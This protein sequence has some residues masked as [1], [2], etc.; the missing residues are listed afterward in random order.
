M[1]DTVIGIMMFFAVI[2]IVAVGVLLAQFLLKRRTDTRV[3]TEIVPAP[4]ERSQPASLTH[5][6]PEPARVQSRHVTRPAGKAWG[7]IAY[8]ELPTNFLDTFMIR[9]FHSIMKRPDI[10]NSSRPWKDFCILNPWA[11][12]MPQV[13]CDMTGYQLT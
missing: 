12:G 1:T 10:S 13:F 7:D 9:N 4:E 5:F 3:E 2:G 11:V 6:L 8:E